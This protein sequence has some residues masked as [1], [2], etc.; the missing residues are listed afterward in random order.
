[1]SQAL[2]SGGPQG[3]QDA[4]LRHILF[5]LALLALMALTVQQQGL[6]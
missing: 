1:M 3:G 4:V 2:W 6:G 5:R